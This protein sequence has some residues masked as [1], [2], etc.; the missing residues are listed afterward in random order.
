MTQRLLGNVLIID[1]SEHLAET[2]KRYVQVYNQYIPQKAYGS[3]ST[4]SSH[5]KLVSETAKPLQ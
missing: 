3:Y 4:T 5:E 1:P 2:I